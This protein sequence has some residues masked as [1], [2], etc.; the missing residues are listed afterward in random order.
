MRL[1]LLMSPI[2]LVLLARLTLLM[3]PIALVVLAR[4]TLLMSPIALVV[5]AWP[6]GVAAHSPEAVETG[7]LGAAAELLGPLGAAALYARGLHR[8]WRHTGRRMA[9]GSAAAFAGG[10]VALGVALAPP[11]D[12]AADGLLVAHMGQHLLLVTVAAPLLAL[13]RPLVVMRWAG[14]GVARVAGGAARLVDALLRRLWVVWAAHSAALWSWHVPALYEAALRD[15]LVH[16]L[17][18][19]SLLGTALLFWS[20]VVEPAWRWRMGFGTAMIW[21]FA[22]AVQCSLLGALLTVAERPWY[23]PHAAAAG[24]WGLDGLD[25]QHLGGAL[26][27]VAGGAAY[28]VG[29]LATVAAWLGTAARTAR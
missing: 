29:A 4:L 15:P 16:A 20:M 18:H 9:S 19:A 22:A 3:S 1:M 21:L 7:W 25:D 27:W 8:R 28:L 6:G 14:P 12:R 24:A 26:M 10:L 11:L 23:A 17:E 13:G 5:L 2:A